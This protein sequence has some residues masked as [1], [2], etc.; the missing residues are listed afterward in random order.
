MGYLCTNIIL[1]LCASVVSSIGANGQTCIVK[2]VVS[3]ATTHVRYASVT[4]VDNSDTTNKFSAITDSTGKY[5]VAVVITS[6]E[7]NN[8]VPTSAIP[9]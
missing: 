1:G 8:S 4:F 6:V 2:G 9:S 5:E 3:V 7:P